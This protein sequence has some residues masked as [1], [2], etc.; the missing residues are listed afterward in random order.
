MSFKFERLEVWKRSIDWADALIDIAENLPRNYQ[1]SLAD[2]LRRAAL[3]VPTNIAKG[4]GRD[5]VKESRYF[6]RIV[7]GS[8]Y[9][10]VSL[11]VM[12]GKPGQLTP[13]DYKKL[14]NEANEIAA[15]LSKLAST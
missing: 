3:S 8:L 7:K 15:I 1:Y 11:L 14:Y 4:S 5:H 12:I 2:Q 9:E 13:V 10:T 6:Y